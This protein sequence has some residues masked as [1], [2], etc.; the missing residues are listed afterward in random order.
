MPGE[1][2]SRFG[3]CHA[4]EGQHTVGSGRPN[5]VDCTCGRHFHF[6]DDLWIRT[7]KCI[8]CPSCERALSPLDFDYHGEERGADHAR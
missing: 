7:D 6:G 2:G 5:G 4:C 1:R 3:E 8:V